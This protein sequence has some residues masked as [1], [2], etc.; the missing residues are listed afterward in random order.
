M[1]DRRADFFAVLLVKFQEQG[2]LCRDP[3][4]LV[5]LTAACLGRIPAS[6]SQSCGI[7]RQVDLPFASIRVAM[8]L[9]TID[10]YE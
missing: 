3:P 10:G 6:W 4:L 1:H 2:K 5:T 9:V 7:G 8:E